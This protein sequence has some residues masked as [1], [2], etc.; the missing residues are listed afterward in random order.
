VTSSLNGLER[1]CDAAIVQDSILSYRLADQ[2]PGTP[3]LFRGAS[4]LYD[5]SLPPG[6]PG[7]VHDVVVCS[8]R[9]GRRIAALSTRPTVHRLRQ[10]IDTERF[11]PAGV[12]GAVPR[13]AVL[14]GNYLRGERLEM[15]TSALD[16][17]GVSFEQVGLQGVT[18]PSPERAIWESDIVIAK[19]RAAL[20]GM[21]CGR[22]VLVFDQFGGDGWV[23]AD[24]YPV[25]EADNFAGLSGPP[26]ASPERL[27]DELSHYDPRMGLLNRELV[28]ANHGARAHTQRLC[29]LLER[30][31][32]PARLDGAPLRELSRLVDLQW[33]AEARAAGFEDASRGAHAHAARVSE[34]AARV[35]GELEAVRRH[36]SAVE[37]EAEAV[38]QACDRA[39]RERDRLADELRRADTILHTRRVRGGLLAGRVADAMRRRLPGQ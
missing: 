25:M 2:L 20:E 16:W 29:E 33:R 9:V 24:R 23:T 14:L 15:V 13:R 1:W 19:G 32:P 4:D 30:V 5:M 39:E 36:A 7:V 18:D 38:R 35:A 6:L 3:Q 8:D 26:V 37:A 31:D 21:A 17:V 28:V 12:P 11:M 10:P 34:H 27:I 22:P